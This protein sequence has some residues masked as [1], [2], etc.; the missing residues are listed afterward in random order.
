MHVTE[1][2]LDIGVTVA[3]SFQVEAQRRHRHNPRRLVS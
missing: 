3:A 1:N 2:P